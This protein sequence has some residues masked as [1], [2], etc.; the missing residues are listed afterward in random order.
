MKVIHI[1]HGKANPDGHNGISRVVYHLNKQEKALGID[2][3]IWAI[4]DDARSH[5]THQRDEFVTVE[6]YPRVRNPFGRHEIIEQLAAHKDQIDVVHFHLIWFY[7]K[8]IITKALKKLGIPFII[9]A[10]GT[11]STRHA[12]TGKRKLVRSLYELD[13]IQ[14]A[15][16]VHVLTRE[17]G[18]GLQRYGYDGPSFVVP[19]GVALE[20]IPAE[21]STRFYADKPYKDRVKAIW[22]GVLRDD[23]NLRSLIHAVAFLPPAVRERLTVVIV[24]PDYRGNKQKYMDLA[25]SLNVRDQFDFVGPL[26]GPEKFDAIKSADF[27]V[28]PSHSEGMSLAVLDALICA[29]PCV[30]TMGCGM[31]YYL[32]NDFFV[33]CEPYAQDIA[34][35][36]ADLFARQDDWEA[37]GANGRALCL[38]TFNWAAIAKE[39]A[40]NY[41]RLSRRTA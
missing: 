13:F 3:Q 36:I 8:N 25:A 17:E 19:N 18:T 31:N 29:K 34:R 20:E 37:M 11:Y 16:E 24:G 26:Y 10:H 27:C 30:L 6:C 12:Y 39:M 21:P 2:S 33:P 5:Y 38:D 32:K 41:A 40:R 14:K 23:K 9:T 15:T 35:G 22:I 28:M 4:V 1:V 7:D